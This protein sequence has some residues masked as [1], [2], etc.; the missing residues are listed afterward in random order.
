MAASTDAPQ[1]RMWD[2]SQLIELSLGRPGPPEKP[3]AW[4]SSPKPC[5]SPSTQT[6]TAR[7]ALPSS[8]EDTDT[9]VLEL[10]L[11]VPED[12][13]VAFSSERLIVQ[14]CCRL[15][16]GVTGVLHLDGLVDV[17]CPQASRQ[18]LFCSSVAVIRKWSTEKHDRLPCQ[19]RPLACLD[20]A[21]SDRKRCCH[22]PPV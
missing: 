20:P 19:G 10:L 14:L 5:S 16:W 15:C 3:A 1:F 18:G 17:P 9:V 21:C 13:L 4:G 12:I 8:S 22:S 7:G 6:S 2:A 11:P